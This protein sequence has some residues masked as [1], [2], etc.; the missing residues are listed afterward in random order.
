M[1]GAEL[2][3]HMDE[4]HS[5]EVDIRFNG[6]PIHPENLSAWTI[7][8]RVVHHGSVSTHTHDTDGS[9]VPRTEEEFWGMGKI[10]LH[11]SPEGRA[12]AAFSTEQ[13]A[14][15]N[16]DPPATVRVMEVAPPQFAGASILET[17]WQELDSILERLLS[18][19]PA[20]DGKDSGRAEAMVYAIA[21][22]TNPYKVDVNAIRKEARAR[23]RAQNEES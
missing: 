15:D 8:H 23:Y 19:N 9:P 1:D 12:F 6:R 3:R 11:V 22:A 10:W 21:V 2:A 5:G 18:G 16:L 13:H 4:E 17:Y 7:F 14:K 20:E